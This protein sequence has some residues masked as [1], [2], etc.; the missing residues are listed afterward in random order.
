MRFRVCVLLALAALAA[1]V[2]A[3][4]VPGG[5]GSGT[6]AGDPLPTGG[7]ANAVLRKAS[8][9]DGDAAWNDLFRV[10]S[11]G[12]LGIGPPG[13]VYPL[14]LE[15]SN[16]TDWLVGFANSATGAGSVYMSNGF[17]SGMAVVAG[18]ATDASR[19]AIQIQK[20]GASMFQVMGDGRTEVTALAGVGNRP[21]YS[22]SVG[23]LT[24]S[25]SDGSL[26]RQL[27]PITD[28]LLLTNRLQGL[29]YYWRDTA[30]WGT[31]REVGLDA[32]EV[33]KVIPEV[34]GTNADGTLSLDYPKLTAVLIEA[35]K[36][37]TV[38]VQQ[39]E[40]KKP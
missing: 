32:R 10:N 20:S 33:Q 6:V 4:V 31:Q 22:T 12:W 19:Y 26:K 39:L 1:P 40:K 24:N 23:S 28:G 2:R 38:R 34:V 37:L 11:A 7:A 30:K 27:T 5:G 14:T 8:A 3:Q 9:S 36:E 29:R 17:G 25:A 35:V 13:P 18:S 21:V 16:A 15:A